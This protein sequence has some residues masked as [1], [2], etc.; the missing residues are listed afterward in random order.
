MSDSQYHTTIQQVRQSILK[1]LEKRVPEGKAAWLKTT[2]ESLMGDPE[3]WELFTSFSAVPR[4]TG[5]ESAQLTKE[6][7]AEAE[8]HR[9]GWKPG[10]WSVDELGRVYLLLCYADQGKE[11][12]LD[13]LEKIFVSSDMNEAV[14]LYKGLPV[15]PWPES[16]KL[17]AAEGVRSNI[18]TV[19]NAIALENPYPKEYLD[20]DPFNQIVLKALFVGSPLYKIDGLEKRANA[21]L[22]KILVEYSQE[23]RSAG[24]IVSPELWRNVGPFID[25][26]FSEDIK[27][28]L[29]QTDPLQVKGGALALLSSDYSGKEEL[30][31]EHKEVVRE[32]DENNISWDDIGKEFET[33]SR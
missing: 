7:I 24:R 33:V 18:T 30:L 1:W 14:A 2:G 10:K 28:L 29:N 8:S 31:K 32:I 9:S 5:K 3:D 21:T 20:Q 26:E 16:L 4:H 23:R 15:Y 25:D 12:F 17:R 22:A 6:E 13:R 11:A 19:F 27:W